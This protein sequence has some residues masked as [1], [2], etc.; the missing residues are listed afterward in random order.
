MSTLLNE[1][2]PLKESALADLAGAT[3]LAALEQ[4]KAAWL[5]THGKWTALMKR[6]GTLPKEEKPAV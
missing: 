6:L 1:I 5:G 2:E 4:A 3:D